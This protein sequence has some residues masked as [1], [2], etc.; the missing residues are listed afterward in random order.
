MVG[1]EQQEQLTPLLRLPPGPPPADG[2]RYKLTS[3]R[4]GATLATRTWAPPTTRQIKA[5]VLLVHGGGWHSGYYGPLAKR[6]TAEGLFVAAYDQPG[7]GYSEVDPTAPNGHLH[8]LVPDDLVDEVY[9]AM[10]W[11]LLEAAAVTGDRQSTSSIPFF[12][13]GESLGGALVL[14]AAMEKATF[15]QRRINL[16]G[17]IG[18]GTLLRAHADMLPP[19]LLVRFLVYLARY[20]PRLALPATDYE[21]TFDDYFGDPQWAQV[22]RSDPKI[23][24][25]PKF[26]LGFATALLSSGDRLLQSAQSFPVPLLAIHGARDCRTQ[27]SAVQ[28]FVD[29]VGPEKAQLV[30]IDTNGHQ[31]LQDVPDKTQVVIEKVALWIQKRLSSPL[32]I[33]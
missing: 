28:E 1:N 31:L 14:M 5:V 15:R 26:T 17:V 25:S 29:K 7:C 2:S 23:C 6:L 9:E 30:Q 22:A 20:Y 27:C 24:V 4:G 16:Q 18:L 3:P 12:L 11:A 8:V 21:T 32:P 13:L 10:D 19:P 33:S